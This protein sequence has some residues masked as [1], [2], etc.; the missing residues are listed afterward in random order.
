MFLGPDGGHYRNSNYARRI[1]RPA[2][3]GRHPPANHSPGRLVVIDATTWPDG[4]GRA[5]AARLAAQPQD[6]D[7]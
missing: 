7:G 1:F 2:C 3:D 6:M 5:D 4:Q